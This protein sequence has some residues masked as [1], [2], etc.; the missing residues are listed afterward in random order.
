[1]PRNGGG[2]L[3]SG[4]PQG[5]PSSA[6]APDTDDVH[7]LA[8]G[9][10]R[11]ETVDVAPPTVE[12]LVRLETQVWSAL[13][14]GDGD[15]DRRLLSDDFIGVYP[16]GFSDR[17]GHVAQLADGPT[18]AWFEIAEP[19]LVAIAD[20]AA[21]LAYRARFRRTTADG[22]DDEEAMYVSSLWCRRGATW[23]NVFSQDTPAGPD[24]C[25]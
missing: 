3:T 9:A 4:A 10:G 16:T 15:A 22:A 25:I 23:T 1:V 24:V 8:A 5:H 12:E 14:V 20:D 11:D 2:G 19:H 13:V 21:I 17:Q 18:V 6:A 7:A